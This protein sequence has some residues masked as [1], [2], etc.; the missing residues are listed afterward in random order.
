MNTTKYYEDNHERIFNAVD[1]PNWRVWK[2][3][4]EYGI[5]RQAK[6]QITS[7]D[8]LLR[9][10]KKARN[11][12]ALYVSISTFLNPQSNHGFFINQKQMTGK[13][14]SYP[15]PGYLLAD[16]I[17]LDSYFFI[18]VDSEK[19]LHIPQRDIWKI[20]PA[21]AKRKDLKL[22]QLRFSGTKGFHLEYERVM[23]ECEHPTDRLLAI[24]EQNKS[25]AD[26]LKKLDLQTLDKTHLNILQDPFRVCEIGRAHV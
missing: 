22:R 20:I 10:I 23:P 2:T 26:N 11:P 17:L 4:D 9:F 5:V 24:K 6:E 13:G 12:Q 16:C 3:T 25:I 14:Y 7:P 1:H 8:K 15:K 21:L 19:G 18:D